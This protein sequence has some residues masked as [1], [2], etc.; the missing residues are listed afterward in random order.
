M[1]WI[2]SA[3]EQVARHPVFF[4]AAWSALR[5]SI[6]PSYLAA[7]KAIGDQGVLGVGSLGL[8]PP[9][10]ADW[11]R[12][13]RLRDADVEEVRATVRAFQIS[14]PKVAIAVHALARAARGRPVGGSGVEEAPSKRGVPLWHPRPT[15]EFPD[16]SDAVLE[17]ARTRL[18]APTPPDVLAALARWPGY[19]IR[20][21]RGARRLI[22]RPAGKQPAARIRRAIQEA[23]RTLPH[24]ISLQWGALKE[25]GLDEEERRDIG[26]VLA[27][28]DAAMPNEVLLTSY[29]WVAA[30][31]PR[32][33]GE[34]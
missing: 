13:G 28:Y 19:M 23:V 34:A 12:L 15:F 8:P 14:V 21:W 17:E 9:N 2:D 1:G 30:G 18:D 31:S 6:G 7:A 24:V 25:R 20:A 32:G 11:I 33:S 26:D 10:D 27:R 4:T 22:G 3:I 16:E 5:P 29:L